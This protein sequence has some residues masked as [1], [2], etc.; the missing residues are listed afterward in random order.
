M[1]TLL[2]TVFAITLVGEPSRVYDGDTLTINRQSVRLYGID[3]PELNEPYGIMSRNYLRSL[4]RGVEVTCK[5]T[6]KTT[7]QRV[8]AHCYLPSGIELNQAMVEVGMAL[9]CRGYSGGAYRQFEPG[10]AR[11]RLTNKGYCK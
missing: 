1:N 7:Y 3:A 4:V 5:L 2:A 9:D 8:V 6:G 10:W 11:D